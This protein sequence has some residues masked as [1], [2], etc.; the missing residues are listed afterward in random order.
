MSHKNLSLD[1]AVAEVEQLLGAELQSGNLFTTEFDLSLSFN[2][3]GEGRLSRSKPSLCKAPSLHHNREK[4][5]KLG[6]DRPFLIALGIHDREG[7]LKPQMA[8]KLKQI[9]RFIEIVDSLLEESQLSQDATWRVVDIGSG[10]GYLT[11]AL[12]DHLASTRLP[13]RSCWH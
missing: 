5:Y 6:L 12:Y 10:K 4:N 13:K 9:Q 3:R 8:S 11:F 1:S 2:R 7:R